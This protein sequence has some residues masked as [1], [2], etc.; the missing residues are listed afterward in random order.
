MPTPLKLDINIT[1]TLINQARPFGST[2]YCLRDLSIKL[3]EDEKWE[4]FV[5]E[6]YLKFD[7]LLQARNKEK[8][9]HVST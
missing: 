6:I 9:H 7:D 5:V 4:N 2:A 3:S 1:S 8:R